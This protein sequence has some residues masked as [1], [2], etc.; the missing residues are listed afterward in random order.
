MEKTGCKTICGAPTTLV[1]KGLMMMM[2]M[3]YCTKRIQPSYFQW[4]LDTN[5]CCI[6]NTDSYCSVTSHSFR[7]EWATFKNLTQLKFPTFMASVKNKT[8]WKRKEKNADSI[9]IKECPAVKQLIAI[10][11]FFFFNSSEI[12]REI[13]QTLQ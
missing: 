3:M 4:L 1:V 12:V 9:T 8:N 7:P 10:F 6:T 11:F 13:C 2:M 5:H